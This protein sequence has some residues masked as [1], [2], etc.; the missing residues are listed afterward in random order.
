MISIVK[1][2]GA[3]TPGEL[4]LW[5]LQLLRTSHPVRIAKGVYVGEHK[6]TS[7]NVTTSLK[8]KLKIN[9]LDNPYIEIPIINKPLAGKEF[10]R[11]VKLKEET[12]AALEYITRN[13]K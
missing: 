10:E 3:S 1:S 6:R 7:K 12:E 8:F 11:A 13:Q 9:D 4:Y 2:N 5:T